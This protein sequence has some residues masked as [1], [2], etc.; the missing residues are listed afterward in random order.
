MLR[1][2]SNLASYSAQR[3]YNNT[4]KD[5]E[6]ALKELATGS[7]FTNPGADP[8]GQAIAEGLNAQTRGSMAALSN[9]ENATGFVAIAEGSLAEQNNIIIRMR[10]LAVQAAS[11][12]LSDVERGYLDDEYQQ[13]IQEFDRIAMSTTYGSQALLDGSTKEYEFQVGVNAGD[14]NI[15]RYTNDTDTT[16]SNVGIDGLSVEDKSDARSSLKYLDKAM[17]TMAAARAKLGAIQGRFD[18]TISHLQSQVE[19]VGGAYARMS[20][21]NIPDAVS[22]VR[23]GQILAQYQAAALA[24]TNVM[25][26][27][28]LRL[29]A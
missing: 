23:R 12:T 27:S 2:A 9:T 29:I 24:E 28:A 25:A 8:A 20:E 3:A 19:N 21:T 5:T 6:R 7:R 14:E 17:H 1:I 11:D 4:Q 13:L 18:S 16:A 15:I 10:E 22:R 26:G